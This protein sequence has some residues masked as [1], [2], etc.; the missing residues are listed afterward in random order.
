MTDKSRLENKIRMLQTTKSDQETNVEIQDINIM[1]VSKKDDGDYVVG[2]LA[3]S[4]GV[5]KPN[6]SE[7][8]QR[9]VYYM[10]EP[11]FGK[12][13]ALLKGHSRPNTSL[14]HFIE[15]CILISEVQFVFTYIVQ[16]MRFIRYVVL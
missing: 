6:E 9:Y 2:E 8:T 16:F 5:L 10:G 1:Q 4:A 7:L 11:I 14:P 3:D 15:L 13:Y 12:Q